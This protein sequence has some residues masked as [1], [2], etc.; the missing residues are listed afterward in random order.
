M[1][2]PYFKAI[3]G[4]SCFCLIDG[5]LE[6]MEDFVIIH[7]Q[8]DCL[9]IL[10]VCSLSHFLCHQY[11]FCLKKRKMNCIFVLL[12]RI[13]SYVPL[14]TDQFSPHFVLFCEVY[15]LCTGRIISL[16]RAC[17]LYFVKR[18]KTENVFK[19]YI[20]SLMKN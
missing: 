7:T 10:R 19:I 15:I 16:P 11:Y 9:W 20:N 3:A 6:E 12:S 17:Y 13:F 1:R 14:P 5:F 2:T 4:F 18:N 8:L